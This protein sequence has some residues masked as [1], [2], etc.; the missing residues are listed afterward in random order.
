MGMKAKGV[1]LGVRRAVWIG[2][3]D[4]A[5][6]VSFLFLLSTGGLLRWILPPGRGGGGRGWRAASAPEVWGLTRHEWGSLHFWIS[7]V[8]LAAIALHLSLHWKWIAAGL[9]GR[10][11]WVA[12]VLAASAALALAVVFGPRS[13]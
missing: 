9:G 5:A 12:V 6:F 4:V 10:G 7:L 2:A 13:G 8:F 11:R 1:L 3:A